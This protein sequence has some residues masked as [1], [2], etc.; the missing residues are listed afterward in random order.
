MF[1]GLE[2]YSRWVPR[3]EGQGGTNFIVYETLFDPNTNP[4]MFANPRE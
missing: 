1:S 2:L 3:Q 4:A